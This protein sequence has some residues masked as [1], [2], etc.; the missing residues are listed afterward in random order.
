MPALFIISFCSAFQIYDPGP[1]GLTISFSPAHVTAFL[2]PCAFAFS[3]ARFVYYLI[4][5]CLPW[6]G[7]LLM[8]YF[9]KW[10]LKGGLVDWK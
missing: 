2:F 9:K 7:A 8:K 3:G 10:F 1:L 4:L 5:F 6:V